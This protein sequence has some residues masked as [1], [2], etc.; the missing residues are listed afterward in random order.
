VARDRRVRSLTIEAPERRG[1]AP[2]TLADRLGGTARRAAGRALPVVHRRRSRLRLAP[3]SAVFLERG[4]RAPPRMK[5]ERSKG[6][7]LRHVDSPWERNGTDV[8]KIH[9]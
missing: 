2:P 8:A 1:V 4:P 6:D 5:T 7:L 9:N 3:A